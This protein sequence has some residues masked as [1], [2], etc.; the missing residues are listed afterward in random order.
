MTPQ[1]ERD[2]VER[3][4]LVEGDNK[5][6]IEQVNHLKGQLR[7]LDGA[8]A[9]LEKSA[10]KIAS[11]HWTVK[12]LTECNARGAAANKDQ[13]RQIADFEANITAGTETI[14]RLTRECEE[15]RAAFSGLMNST[16]ITIADLKATIDGLERSETASNKQIVELKEQVEGKVK[17]ATQLNEEIDGLKK[18]IGELVDKIT[19]LG[20]EKD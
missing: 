14:Q 17:Y 16:N 10:G 19:A 4:K 15:D 5:T 8:S 18:T 3:L 13:I 9:D 7:S 2:T 1:D 6:L 20:D 11:L 12:D